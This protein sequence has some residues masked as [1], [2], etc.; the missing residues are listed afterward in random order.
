M[1]LLHDS[2]GDRSQT[3]AVIPKIV[4]ALQSRG[5]QFVTVA[6]LPGRSRDEVMPLVPPE[7]RWQTGWIVRAPG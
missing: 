1:I 4:A 2:G 5:F 6:S 3:V 7:S